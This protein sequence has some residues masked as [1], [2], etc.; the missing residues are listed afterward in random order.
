MS[1]KERNTKKILVRALCWVLAL[2]MLSG[3]ITY[4]ISFFL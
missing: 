2:L 4:I 1:N 3:T